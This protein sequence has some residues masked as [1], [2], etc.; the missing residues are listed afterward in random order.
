MGGVIEAGKA[1]V[2]VGIGLPC[3][4]GRACAGE[5][6][7]S[8]APPVAWWERWWAWGVSPIGGGE[9]ATEAMEAPATA[10]TAVVGSC[11]DADEE[12]YWWWWWW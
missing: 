7:P 4:G 11:D 9:E 1:A 3:T 6:W 8:E 5:S 2:D 10:E 12:E